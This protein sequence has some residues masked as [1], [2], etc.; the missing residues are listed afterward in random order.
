[1]LKRLLFSALISVFLFGCKTEEPV[2][3]TSIVII[4]K[5]VSVIGGGKLFELNS[6][7]GIYVEGTSAELQN[8][9]NYI[10]EKLNKI[11]GYDLKVASLPA[12]APEGNNIILSTTTKDQELGDQGYSIAIDE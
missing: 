6:K 5:P 12:T 9:G 10:A 7:S 8:I 4:P 1:M 2:D 3:L 11:T